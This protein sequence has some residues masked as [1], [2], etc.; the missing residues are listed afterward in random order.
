MTWV[1]YSNYDD[2]TQYNSKVIEMGSNEN[3]TVTFIGV[4][5]F[6]FMAEL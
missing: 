3:V 6:P 5:L 2:G 1:S 4:S